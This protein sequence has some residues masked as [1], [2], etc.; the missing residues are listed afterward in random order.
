MFEQIFN[1]LKSSVK[2][3]LSGIEERFKIPEPDGAFQ[4]IRR[5]GIADNPLTQGCISVDQDSWRIEA[6]DEREQRKSSQDSFA[7]FT[8]HLWNYINHLPVRVVRL[9]EVAEPENQECILACRA[10][11]K[12]DIKEGAYLLLGLNRPIDILGMKNSYTA[13]HHITVSDTTD[14]K[15]Y[16]VRL[17]FKKEH[18]PGTIWVDYPGTIWVDI[19]FESSGI[20]WIKNV[21][22]LQAPVK[23]AV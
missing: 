12:T 4:L 22:L 19:K 7:D 11:I 3:V 16:E 2:Q 14:W 13:I 9:F 17:H 8:K 1:E 6:Y 15:A 23:A 5:F 21:E 18:Y 10:H 20:L